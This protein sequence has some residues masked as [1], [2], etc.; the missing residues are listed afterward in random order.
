MPLQILLENGLCKP[1]IVCDYCEKEIETAEDGCYAHDMNVEGFQTIYFFH[2]GECFA[3]FL[4]LNPC[5]SGPC[6]GDDQLDALLVYLSHNL[7]M[8]WEEARAY[9][10]MNRM[11]NR[12]IGP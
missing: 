8:D 6:W 7:K 4:E 3:T 12:M 10:E 1:L 11:I 9:V 5:S 2:R